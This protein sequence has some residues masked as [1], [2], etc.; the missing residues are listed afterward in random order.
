MP[1]DRRL[2]RTIVS[3]PFNGGGAGTNASRRVHITCPNHWTPGM[4]E[5]PLS[6]VA[7]LCVDFRRSARPAAPG[8][9]EYNEPNDPRD[10][11]PD[12]GQ[13]AADAEPER[14][15]DNIAHPIVDRDR[16]RLTVLR[17]SDADEDPFKPWRR[18][19]PTTNRPAPPVHLAGRKER[20]PVLVPRTDRHAARPNLPNH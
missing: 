7:V 2:I 11:D 4:L 9:S 13:D 1:I 5:S 16:G 18:L 14:R 12:T 8:V 3:M 15:C 17:D 10:E 6:A 20:D 19:V